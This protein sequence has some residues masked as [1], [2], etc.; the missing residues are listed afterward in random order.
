MKTLYLLRHAK[1]SWSEPGLTD[2]DRPLNK[3]GRKAAPKMGELMAER[4]LAPDLIL[5]STA[6]RARQT[7]ELVAPACNF[8]GT[9]TLTDELYLAPVETY[10]ELL[11]QLDDDVNAV[12][13]VAH[14][15]GMA[16]M[17]A[18]LTGR[19]LHFPTAALAKISLPIDSW[20]DLTADTRGELVELW[21]PKELD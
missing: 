19:S 5:C 9:I 6:V 2:H 7:V 18:Y 21:R 4:D 14:N 17:V 12:M 15:P 10:L 8:D 3:R 16:N 1:S 13:T 20:R 11:A